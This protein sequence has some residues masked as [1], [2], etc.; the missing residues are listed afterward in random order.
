[1]LA[2]NGAIEFKRFDPSA[3]QKERANRL[4]IIQRR[5]SLRSRSK[6]RNR[7][8]S[9]DSRG[10]NISNKRRERLDSGYTSRGS[11][12][13]N[14]SVSSINSRNSRA[15][16][17]SRRSTR[18]RK[19][20]KLP[21]GKAAAG[22]SKAPPVSNQ[23]E[24]EEMKASSSVKGNSV[25]SMVGSFKQPKDQGVTNGLELSDIDNR[26]N[27]LQSFLKAAKSSTIQS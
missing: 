26:L 12:R 22:R 6:S 4:A 25:L 10:S 2:T 19:Q 23:R 16:H 5:K 18:S 9:C 7:D 15:S 3:Y 1:M 14:I 17:S 11:E 20:V 21:K 24:K 13:S 27:A 8:N